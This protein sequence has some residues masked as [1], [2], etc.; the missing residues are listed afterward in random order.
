M[1]KELEAAIGV[2]LIA[3]LTLAVIISYILLQ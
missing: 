1:S 2:A 3:L